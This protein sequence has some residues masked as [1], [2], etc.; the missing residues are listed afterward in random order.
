MVRVA[1]VNNHGR[2]PW[3]DLTGKARKDRIPTS[4]RDKL[5]TCHTAIG[6]GPKKAGNRTGDERWMRVMI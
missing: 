4:R 6:R 5:P 3:P 1:R 2:S